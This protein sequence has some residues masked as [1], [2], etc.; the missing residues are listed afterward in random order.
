VADL[1]EVGIVTKEKSAPMRLIQKLKS[2]LAPAATAPAANGGTAVAG[3]VQ[4]VVASDE[5]ITTSQQR[6]AVLM[7]ASVAAATPLRTIPLFLVSSNPA[8]LQSIAAAAD[9]PLTPVPK[10]HL[11]YNADT[12][13]FVST[14]PAKSSAATFMLPARLASVA[15][16]NTVDGKAP[17]KS[18][19]RLTNAA[20]KAKAK[21]P[22]RP[23]SA[24]AVKV[25]PPQAR[26]G[27]IKCF[28]RP[29]IGGKSVVTAVPQRAK[30]RAA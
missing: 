29:Q 26:G 5:A 17:A 6:L 12:Q 22:N 20:I 30:R 18:A 4:R 21:A 19:A 23:T 28:V 1:I 2:W 8:P 24:P 15:K 3:F 14:A 27:A 25:C 11:V 7:P 9:V 13:T 10:L 16:L